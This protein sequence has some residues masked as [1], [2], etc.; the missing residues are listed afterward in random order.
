MVTKIGNTPSFNAGTVVQNEVVI[1]SILALEPK[2]HRDWCKNG[3]ATRK[4]FEN[5]LKSQ[6]DIVKIFCFLG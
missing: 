6:Q 4:K 1:N 5:T 3:Y 2:C